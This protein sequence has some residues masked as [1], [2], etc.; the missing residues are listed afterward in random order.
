MAYFV[1]NP[2]YY[3]SKAPFTQLFSTRERSLTHQSCMFP[4]PQLYLGILLVRAASPI[5][6]RIMKGRVL[7]EQCAL[8][9]AL[10]LQLSDDFYVRE[11]QKL[12]LNEQFLPSI[13]CLVSI[14]HCVNGRG[15]ITTLLMNGTGRDGLTILY[16]SLTRVIECLCFIRFI[17]ID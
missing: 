14:F 16:T 13:H 15:Q 12:T 3:P 1:S 2:V 11:G 4:H 6:G 5:Y 17:K 10:S 8:Q 9:S 7:M